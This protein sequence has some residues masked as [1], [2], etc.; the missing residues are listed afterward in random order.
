MLWQGF[1]SHGMECQGYP[2]RDPG[3]LPAHVVS[4][5]TKDDGLELGCDGCVRYL[6]S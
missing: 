6:H 3:G 5:R 2:G 4:G 1:E